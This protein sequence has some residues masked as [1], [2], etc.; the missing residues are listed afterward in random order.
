MN[1]IA[2]S[3]PILFATIIVTSIIF[4]KGNKRLLWLLVLI[5]LIAFSEILKAIGAILIYALPE[6]AVV[7]GK[8][9]PYLGIINA[10]VILL[11]SFPLIFLSMKNKIPPTDQPPSKRWLWFSLGVVVTF[12]AHL[13]F[14]ICLFVPGV[15]GSDVPAPQLGVTL[16][17]AIIPVGAFLLYYSSKFNTPSQPNLLRWLVFLC[18]VLFS[19]STLPLIL[20]L[21]FTVP[22]EMKTTYPFLAGVMSFGITFFS[23]VAV[24]IAKDYVPKQIDNS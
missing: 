5:Y 23:L 12:L 13:A 8:D 15:I 20:I 4:R 10:V 22:T 14:L 16:N 7:K 6:A 3:F 2:K 11:L 1:I 9:F 17:L 18:V 24:G 21:I 19:S